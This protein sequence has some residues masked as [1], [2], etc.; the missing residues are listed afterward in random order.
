MG[1]TPSWTEVTLA[2]EKYHASRPVLIA[3]ETK[4]TAY[5]NSGTESISMAVLTNKASKVHLP[6]RLITNEESRAIT[7]L[8]NGKDIVQQ[9]GKT[10]IHPNGAR[11]PV[12]VPVLRVVGAMRATAGCAKCHEVPQGTLLGA[13]SYTLV[14]ADKI[15]PSFP[16][17]LGNVPTR[18]SR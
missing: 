6:T 14:L 3:L 5:L 9:A 11:S 17:V 12:E 4:P 13:F 16:A 1:F 18:P 2:G 10:Q 8:R 15:S 7:E